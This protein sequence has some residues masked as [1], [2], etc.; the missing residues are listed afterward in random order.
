M[1]VNVLP[2]LQTCLQA[3]KPI[4]IQAPGPL[5]S[6]AKIIKNQP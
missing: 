1:S 3:G 5:Y 4:H 6:K 2:C